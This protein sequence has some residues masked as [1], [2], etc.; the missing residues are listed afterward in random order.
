M[1]LPRFQG[2]AATTGRSITYRDELVGV[3]VATI[4][5][6]YWLLHS[7]M[8]KCYAVHL[9]NTAVIPQYDGLKHRSG[10]LCGALRPA[11]RDLRFGVAGE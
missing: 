9:I 10:Q 4:A 8:A 5:N 3:A 7:L 11:W 6:G 2:Y 1:E